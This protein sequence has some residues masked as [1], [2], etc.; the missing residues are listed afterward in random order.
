V[1]FDS[2]PSKSRLAAPATTPVAP[3][4]VGPANVEHVVG[5][6][7]RYVRDLARAHGVPILCPAGKPLIR[8]ADLETA[9]ERAVRHEPKPEADELERGACGSHTGAG[10]SLVRPHAVRDAIAQGAGLP[11]PDEDR[12]LMGCQAVLLEHRLLWGVLMREGMREGKGFGLTW[13]PLDL[14]RGAVRLDGT[15]QTIRGPG[16]STR[17]W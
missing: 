5:W 4:F 2:Y 14:E 17:A 7:W 13:Q 1:V 10:V 11:V 15:R 9:I 16:L 12:R 3:V 8:L 6:T